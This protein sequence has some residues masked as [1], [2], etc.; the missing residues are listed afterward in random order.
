M[1]N[2]DLV[3]SLSLIVSQP[4]YSYTHGKLHQLVTNLREH[5]SRENRE[6]LTELFFSELPSIELRKYLAKSVLHIPKYVYQFGYAAQILQDKSVSE[7]KSNLSKLQQ[8]T[9]PVLITVAK[10][11]MVTKPEASYILHNALPNSKLISYSDG[12][13]FFLHRYPLE[14]AENIKSLS[15]QS[16]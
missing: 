13:H 15:F 4:D 3:R 16:I 7:W 14:L 11:D 9:M 10:N 5:P 8:L 2:P 1:Q 6:K 12:G